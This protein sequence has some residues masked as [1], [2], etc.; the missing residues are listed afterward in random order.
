MNLSL[1][2]YGIENL[3]T[4]RLSFLNRP[5]V[6]LLII[7]FTLSLTTVNF[8]FDDAIAEEKPLTKAEQ[9]EQLKKTTGLKGKKLREHIQRMQEAPPVEDEKLQA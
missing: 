2:K 8:V 6:H 7:A 3:L 9:L 4:C 5:C 1:G